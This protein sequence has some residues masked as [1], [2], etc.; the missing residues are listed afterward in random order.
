MTLLKQ[1]TTGAAAVAAL[2]ASAYA[3]FAQPAPVDVD[4]T[5]GLAQ[6]DQLTARIDADPDVFI[7]CGSR[8]IRTGGG[9]LV[10]T[11]FCQAKDAAD[12]AVLCFT[13]DADL[14]DAI[15]ALSDFAFITFSFVDDGAGG[16]ECRRV[17]SSTQS[18]YLFDFG[19]LK[20]KK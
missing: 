11:G 10:R 4:L 18:F 14:L 19:S 1:L 7:G 2:A 6:G 8:T 17:G 5:A 16:F 15:R 9:T 20:T 3:G 12:E 13:Q